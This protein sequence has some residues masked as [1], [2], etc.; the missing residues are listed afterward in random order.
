MWDLIEVDLVTY[1][2]TIHFTVL[3]I[4]EHAPLLHYDLEILHPNTPGLTQMECCD[5]PKHEAVNR[6]E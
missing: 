4:F 1:I 2:L 3:M 6:I 5:W